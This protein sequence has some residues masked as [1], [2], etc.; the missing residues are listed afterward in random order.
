MKVISLWQPWAT[1]SVLG[2]KT[3]ETRGWAAPKSIIGRRIGIAATKN[4]VPE[5]RAAFN[6]PEFQRFYAETGLP[7]LEQL[8]RGAVVGSVL[9]HSCDPID[10]ETI[11]DLTD[12]ELNFGWFSVG[13]YAWRMR[14]QQAFGPYAA[15]GAQGLWDWEP[16][17]DVA[18]LEQ[19]NHRGVQAGPA[20]L[21]R[22]LHAALRHE[23][24]HSL[25]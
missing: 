16:P 25:S 20:T 5:Q 4:I 7:P 23:G 9:L 3:I 15:R 14:H 19:D 2:H 8:P 1:L 21:G 12:M 18:A 22:R 17:N 24:L 6:D 10:E 13:R 11:D